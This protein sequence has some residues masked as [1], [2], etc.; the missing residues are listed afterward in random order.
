MSKLMYGCVEGNI[1]VEDGTC[2]EGNIFVEDGT[3]VEAE[4]STVGKSQNWWRRYI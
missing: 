4:K 3:C 2:V 1:F